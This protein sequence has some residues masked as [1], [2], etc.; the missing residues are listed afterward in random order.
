MW[1]DRTLPALAVAFEAPEL[2]LLPVL[3]GVRAAGGK[4][5][6]ASEGIGVGD[7]ACVEVPSLAPRRI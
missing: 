1:V 3:L 6:R 2:S 7:Q 5:L 4:A